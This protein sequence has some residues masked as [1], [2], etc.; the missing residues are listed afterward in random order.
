MSRKNSNFEPR[1]LEQDLLLDCIDNG[2]IPSV[3]HSHNVDER[4]EYSQAINRCNS[5]SSV[6]WFSIERALWKHLPFHDAHSNSSCDLSS[7]SSTQELNDWS[8][9]NSMKK[10]LLLTSK[11]NC[12]TRRELSTSSTSTLSWKTPLQDKCRD[13][14]QRETTKLFPLALAA[15]SSYFSSSSFGN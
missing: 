15:D 7:S 2:R 11:L 6:D 5:T 1:R 14:Y 13:Q 8:C 9:I 12:S 4:T 3:R 10:Q